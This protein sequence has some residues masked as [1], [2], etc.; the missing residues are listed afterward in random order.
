MP[1]PMQPAILDDVPDFA[2]FIVYRAINDEGLIHTLQQLAM[3]ADGQRV[4]MGLSYRLVN[5]LDKTVP[6]LM[7]MPKY[8][9]G[10][11]ALP[12]DQGDLVVWLRVGGDSQSVGELAHLA[13]AINILLRDHFVEYRHWDAFN[14]SGRDLS[15]YEDGTENPEGDA[16]VSAA[17][18]QE[19]ERG[20]SGGSFLALQPWRHNLEKFKALSQPQQDDIIGRHLSD[21]E[22]FSSAPE[23][24]HVKRSA[25]ER[26]TPEAF[27]LRRSMPWVKGAENGLIFVAFGKDFS[28]FDSIMNR[29]LGHDDGI[30]DGLFSFTQPVGGGFYWC[31]PIND[32]NVDLQ[33]LL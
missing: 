18:V 3:V 6:G 7:T 26:F 24:A 25:Q 28:A 13:R 16:A 2:K 8:T 19:G 17:V 22:E 10:D 14:Y 5:K 27:M 33:H 15:G 21:N 32:G 23:S 29:M 11:V 4:L 30:V 1:L 20:L 31:P 12:E 9:L